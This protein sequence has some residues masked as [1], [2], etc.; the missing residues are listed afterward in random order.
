M[1]SQLVTR[2][3]LLSIL[4]LPSV[5][6]ANTIAVE[7][8]PPV[9]HRTEVDIGF[10]VGSEE[11]G[12]GSRFARGLQINAGRRFGDLV[13]LGEYNY[14]GIGRDTTDSTGT[15]S[16]FGVIARYSLLRTRGDRDRRRKRPPVSGDFWLEAGGGIQ[17]IAWD[18]GG[19]LI[20]PDGVV[21]FGLQLDV[22]IGR[23]EAKPRYFGPFVAFRAHM[24]RAPEHDP[25][26]MPSCGGV[27]DRETRPSRNNVG[28]FFH[29]GV[30]WGR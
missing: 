8:E 7:A 19:R 21:G 11:I 6:R 5:A 18:Q 13:L 15:L 9:D 20:R 10:L 27:C 30:N 22:V 29:V 26:V 23:K 14:L 1:R 28:L 4:G 16:R 3:L 24:S 17:R 25:S 2:L 12:G